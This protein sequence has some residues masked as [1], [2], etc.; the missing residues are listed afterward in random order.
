MTIGQA[1]VDGV[2]LAGLGLV[3]YEMRRI[4][5]RLQRLEQEEDETQDHH[6]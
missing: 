2:L 3:I 1:V 6:R 4:G 5:E